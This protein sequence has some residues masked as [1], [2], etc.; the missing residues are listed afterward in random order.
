MVYFRIED[1][2]NCEGIQ[3]NYQIE[4]EKLPVMNKQSVEYYIA[5]EIRKEVNGAKDRKLLSYSKSLGVCLL[6]YNEFLDNELHICIVHDMWYENSICYFSPNQ[7]IKY[8][9]Y[10]LQDALYSRGLFKGNDEITLI[11]FVLDIAD[12]KL[13]NDY[14]LKF[15]KTGLK[16]YASP[17]KDYEVVM[18]Q[19]FDDVTIEIYIDSIYLLYALQLKYKF[20]RSQEVVTQVICEIYQLEDYRFENCEHER[21]AI[22]FLI[23]YLYSE[24]EFEKIAFEEMLK[25]SEKREIFYGYYNSLLQLHGIIYDDFEDAYHL[26]DYND[27]VV[28]DIFWKYCMIYGKNLSQR[29][30]RDEY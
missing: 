3:R 10:S 15:T 4:K 28:S 16:Q 2:A 17:E 8:K 25:Y 23:Q 5:E 19:A 20:L 9:F 6:K 13:L 12:N 21:E 14:L 7:H 11:N 1:I 30:R 18:M 22:I 27:N 26:S 24:T 29:K